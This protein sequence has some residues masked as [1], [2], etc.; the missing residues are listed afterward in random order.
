[1][2]SNK[3]PHE[4]QQIIESLIYAL[5][6][7]DTPLIYIEDTPPAVK[8]PPELAPLL[9]PFFY[10]II[11]IRQFYYS[12]KYIKFV[13]Q[14]LRKLAEIENSKIGSIEDLYI[15]I[16]ADIRMFEELSKCMALGEDEIFRLVKKDGLLYNQEYTSNISMEN[17]GNNILVDTIENSKKH[18]I[19][20]NKNSFFLN[21]TLQLSVEIIYKN[22]YEWIYNGKVS[23]ILFKN[24]DA[25]DRSIWNGMFK[26]KD[27]GLNREDRKRVEVCGKMVYFLRE[28]FTLSAD[29]V[30]R[31]SSHSNDIDNELNSIDNKNSDSK[32]NDNKNNDLDNKNIDNKNND[33]MNNVN[34]DSLSEMI[35]L[36]TN[37]L[38]K[39]FNSLTA[40]LIEK[41]IS[42]I[43]EILFMQNYSIF[44][45]IFSLYGES[46]L[47]EDIEIVVKLNKELSDRTAMLID[48]SKEHHADGSMRDGTIS[49]RLKINDVDINTFILKLLKA[50]GPVGQR[51]HLILLQKLSIEC[52]FKLLRY[53]VSQKDLMEIE[54]ISRFILF[55]NGISYFIERME[56]GIFVR[57]V[58]L[59]ISH[60]K[61]VYNNMDIKSSISNTRSTLNSS[62]NYIHETNNNNFNNTDT[63]NNSNTNFNNTDT[64]NNSNTNFNNGDMNSVN[65]LIKNTNMLISAFHLNNPEI[66]CQWSRFFDIVLEYVQMPYRRCLDEGDFRVALREVVAKLWRAIADSCGES[67]F[68]SFLKDLD[69]D[70]YWC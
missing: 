22:I 7:F 4:E 27:I 62:L 28:I 69:Q 23:D 26:I 67:G 64:N 40:P 24:P 10:P 59:V 47:S 13:N 42:V 56:R 31:L 6:G 3:N 16:S 19:K 54:I 36:R 68:V 55:V 70:R 34:K 49:T 61:Q 11:K 60:I 12:E 33:N 30:E 48:S 21:Y 2:L 14:Y 35:N 65:R 58:Y 52:D 50:D 1:M 18:L 20:N 53:F 17:K 37:K 39:I 46:L 38:C 9:E 32:N 43:Y 29:K 66:F 44:L 5:S 8:T 57:I 45:E 63:N 25:F 51:S 41:E 15:A